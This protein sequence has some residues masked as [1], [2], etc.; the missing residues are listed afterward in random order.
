MLDIIKEN[1]IISII[2]T[3]VIGAL[4][5][6]LWEVIF[7]PSF[8][9]I[10]DVTFYILTLGIKKTRDKVYLDAAKNHS[11][12]GGIFVARHMSLIL[13]SFLIAFSFITF[14]TSYGKANYFDKFEYCDRVDG[15]GEY[16]KCKREVSKER[17]QAV[18]VFTIPLFMLVAVILIY[19]SLKIQ[20][21]Y[22]ITMDFKQYLTI[23]R[24]YMSL[25]EVL[26]LEAKFTR[27]KE[28]VDYQ[29]LMSK[30][31]KIAKDNDQELPRYSGNAGHP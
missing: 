18:A 27:M 4:G 30:L 15:E 23:C 26:M 7:K 21:V 31:G 11:E 9:K 8:K 12:L 6:G 1:W 24:P 20:M 14:Q 28:K 3:L 19:T 5:S 29:E 16:R 2:S 13:A 10:G 17:V 25:E 22:R